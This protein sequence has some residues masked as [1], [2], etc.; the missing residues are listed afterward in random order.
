MI[1]GWRGLLLGIGGDAQSIQV[2]RGV[3]LAPQDMASGCMLMFGVRCNKKV[4]LCIICCRSSIKLQK[5]K[6]RI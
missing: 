6:H 3:F 1:V 4:L 2:A 5:T